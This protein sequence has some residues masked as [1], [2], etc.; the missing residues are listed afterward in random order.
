MIYPFAKR[1]TERATQNLTSNESRQTLSI[2]YGFSC[3]SIRM[4]PRNRVH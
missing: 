4:L 1:K 2:Q 3:T